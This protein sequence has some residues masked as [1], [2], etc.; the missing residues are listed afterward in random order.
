[1]VARDVVAVIPCF[2]W[3]VFFWQLVDERGGPFGDLQ[4]DSGAGITAAESS[5]GEV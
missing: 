2:N 5:S 3:I 1:M 4:D